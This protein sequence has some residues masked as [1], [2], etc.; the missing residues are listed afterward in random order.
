[1]VSGLLNK[2]GFWDKDIKKKWK[3]HKDWI[4]FHAVSVGELNAIY[5]LIE[6]IRLLN[7]NLSVMISCTT[8]AGYNLA[9]SKT[10]N[11]AISVI[12]FPFDIP[13]ILNNLFNIINL[14]L[15]IIAETEI[16]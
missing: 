5:P 6:N 2:L 12:Y 15:I 1:M 16:W 3:L 7:P 13:L 4:W 10:K 9:K 8:E 11:T 14:K